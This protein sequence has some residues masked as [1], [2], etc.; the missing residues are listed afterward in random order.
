MFKINLELLP[1]HYLRGIAFRKV[2]AINESFAIR[3]F[4]TSYSLQVLIF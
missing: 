2:I 1:K 4:E 3:T